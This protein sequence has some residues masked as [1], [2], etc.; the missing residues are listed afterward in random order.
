MVVFSCFLSSLLGKEAARPQIRRPERPGLSEQARLQGTVRDT[1]GAPLSQVI[2]TVINRQT[3]E[4]QGAVTGNEGNFL[5]ENLQ[6]GT[7]DLTAE[8][9]GFP[10][11]SVREI[12]LRDRYTLNLEMK[13]E[14]SVPPDRRLRRRPG[15]E[16]PGAKEAEPELPETSQTAPAFR[17]P[18]PQVEEAET[19]E[20]VAHPSRTSQYQPLGYAGRVSNRPRVE[21]TEDF[22]PVADRWRI[23]FP[24]WDRYTPYRSANGDYPYVRGHWW[25]PFNQNVLKGDY[26]IFGNR[27]F[28]NFS[29]I[30]DSLEEYRRFPVPSP[31]SSLQPN[32]PEF[33]ARG[34]TFLFN[35]NFIL[36]ADLFRG[37]S[38]FKPVDI[39]F[40]I[41]PVFNVN[42]LEAR[43]NAVVNIDVRRF[44]T[45][46]DSHIA[47]Q[48]AFV[49]ARLAETSPFYDFASLRVGTQGFTSDFRGFVFSDNEPGVRLFGNFKANKHQYNLAYF[50]M[51]EK[52]TNSGLNTFRQRRQEVLIANYYIQD[53]LGALG[54]TAQFSAH[55]NHDR[56]SVH[57]DENGF[58]VRPAQVG[59]VIPK[60]ISA[61]Y[62]GWTGD[63]HFGS[64]NIDHAFYQVLGQEIPSQIAGQNAV[65]APL[66]S[67]INAQLAALELSLDRDWKRYKASFFYVSG[68]D[69]PNDNR[70]RGFDS[71]FD[72]VNFAGAGNSFWTRQGFRLTGTGLGLT[73]RFSLN[74]SLRSSKDEGQ[75]NYV[76][77]G[78]YLGGLGMDAEVTPKLR[79]SAN[80][81]VMWFAHTQVLEALLF[82]SGIRRFVG[83]DASLGVKW[84]PWLNNNFII[85]GGVGAFIP[86]RG[87]RDIF[88]SKTLFST[89]VGL[90]VTY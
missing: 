40:R 20:N 70:S 33:F 51:L 23:G 39:R 84:R 44:N 14:E 55:F 79:G 15:Q 24:G 1:A 69:N 47:L 73:Q 9:S 56:P 25:D 65:F 49:E 5:I 74:P 76:N 52:D 88:T 21:A 7:Y 27:W 26:P 3:G 45:R 66:N 60:S 59:N 53:F 19:V 50:N 75:A 17:R 64:W 37:Y 85:N 34:E 61:V 36:S 18:V 63:G 48:E 54:Y 89:F 46:S 35:Q 57:F 16:E 68:D 71:I 86:G 82:Q 30:S 80:V 87:F 32:N 2:I 22:I 11:L 12:I 13:V 72:N 58:L 83:M 43:E 78:L 10:T 8:R 28:L 62:L 90:A 29:A 77:P 6:P 67:D 31:P 41:T 4:Q 42:Y 81:N 38:T